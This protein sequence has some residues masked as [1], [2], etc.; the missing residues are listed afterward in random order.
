MALVH[1]RIARVFYGSHHPEGGLGSKYKLHVKQGINHHYEVFC[2][3][4]Q[5]Q[6]DQLASDIIK[7]TLTSV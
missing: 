2:G 5:E 7:C 1:S 3:V 6:C 4:L